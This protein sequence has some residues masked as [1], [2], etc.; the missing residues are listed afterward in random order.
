MGRDSEND[1]KGL[2]LIDYDEFRKNS[3]R[4]IDVAA[5]TYHSMFLVETISEER[6]LKSK[7]ISLQ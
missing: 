5:G 1:Y 2:S 7:V 6:E 4:V 3:L